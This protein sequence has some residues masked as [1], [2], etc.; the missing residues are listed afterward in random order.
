[1]HVEGKEEETDELIEEVENTEGEAREEE[2]EE[3]EEVE[4]KEVKVSEELFRS[5]LCTAH[6]GDPD[7]L[8]RTSGEFR[9]SNF[10][11]WQL[12]YTELFFVDKYW[13]EMTRE[14][15]RDV[16]RQFGER[17]RRYGS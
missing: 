4:E 12:A 5:K 8:L 16:L 9:L 10:L 3:E 17:S 15:L 2:E 14:D 1:L 6:S 13:P 11:L 7:I